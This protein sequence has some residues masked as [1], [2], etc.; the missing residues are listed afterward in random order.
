MMIYV[1]HCP[2][3]YLQKIAVDLHQS[4]IEDLVA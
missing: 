4:I 2:A 1:M 3:C